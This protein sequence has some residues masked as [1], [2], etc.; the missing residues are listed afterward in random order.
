MDYGSQ[1][2]P[3]LAFYCS[4]IADVCGER[5][6]QT[7]LESNTE[8]IKKQYLCYNCKHL[9]DQLKKMINIILM[10]GKIPGSVVA[11]FGVSF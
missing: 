3:F 1:K 4:L 10:G 2:Q 9:F 7:L 11:H 5:N 6:L 8:C